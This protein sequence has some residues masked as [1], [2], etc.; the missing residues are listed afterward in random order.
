MAREFKFEVH[1]MRIGAT[2]ATGMS[3]ALR[4]KLSVEESFLNARFATEAK[5]AHKAGIP[6]T[7]PLFATKSWIGADDP[8]PRVAENIEEAKRFA[9]E[10]WPTRFFKDL[11]MPV[12]VRVEGF[13]TPLRWHYIVLSD[14]GPFGGFAH[15]RMK[16]LAEGPTWPAEPVVLGAFKV[17]GLT[18]EQA[19]KRERKRG[20]N[21][22]YAPGDRAI[23]FAVLL[24]NAPD[25]LRWQ[26]RTRE[27]W[28]GTSM[29]GDDHSACS[30]GQLLWWIA[31]SCRRNEIPCADD[32]LDAVKEVF[33][34][35]VEAAAS[36]LGTDP[37]LVA[38]FL[39]RD[40]EPSKPIGAK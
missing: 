10:A 26:I 21:P 19:K 35:G 15:E 17:A 31:D 28:G 29:E 39:R 5:S 25:G 7:P 23:A 32:A 22:F 14:G 34:S 13:K 40:L 16:T 12:L 33:G 30:L 2:R 4:C 1:P 3:D 6:H 8:E 11:V 9:V 36:A 24:A 27:S 37:E 18:V 38:Y 20:F